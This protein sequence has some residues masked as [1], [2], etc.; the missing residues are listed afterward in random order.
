[1]YQNTPNPF[2]SETNI[3]FELP[4]VGVVT[5]TIYDATGI[6]LL[7]TNNDFAKGFNNISISNDQLTAGL[8][9][10]EL[11]TAAHNETKKMILT[12]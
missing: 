11:V 12:K 5:L 7:Q 10:Y 9:Y 2:R 4:E 3:G 8:L 1:L 6:L